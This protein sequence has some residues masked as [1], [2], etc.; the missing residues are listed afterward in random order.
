VEASS[1]DV[2]I[3]RVELPPL[4]VPKGHYPTPEELHE[5]V[6][7]GYVLTFMPEPE[8]APDEDGYV[9]KREYDVW[10]RALG[11]RLW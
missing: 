8:P 6:P 10:L 3:R 9:N 11:V 5:G 4:V 1:A 7:T 2:G